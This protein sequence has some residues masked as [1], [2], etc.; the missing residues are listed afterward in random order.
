V[1]TEGT[2]HAGDAVR[3]PASAIPRAAALPAALTRET[4]HAA[5]D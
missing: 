3:E 2:I 5:A 4:E 1:L